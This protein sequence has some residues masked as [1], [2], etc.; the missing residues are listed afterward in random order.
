MQNCMTP[1]TGNAVL[2]VLN[3]ESPEKPTRNRFGQRCDVRLSQQEET[4]GR[5]VFELD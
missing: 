5:G 4:F 2:N 1:A 3:F